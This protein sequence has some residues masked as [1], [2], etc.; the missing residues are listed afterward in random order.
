MRR[1]G[2]VPVQEEEEGPGWGLGHWNEF[3]TGKRGGFCSLLRKEMG[4][5]DVRKDVG[6]QGERIYIYATI[7]AS[8]RSNGPIE[9]SRTSRTPKSKEEKFLQSFIEQT[10]TVA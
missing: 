10:P 8:K 9:T 5:R 2:A 1:Y 3:E 4:R 6:R 7:R